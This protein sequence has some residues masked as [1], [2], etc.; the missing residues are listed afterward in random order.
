METLLKIEQILECEGKLQIGKDDD[1]LSMYLQYYYS[2]R[3]KRSTPI[4]TRVDVNPKGLFPTKCVV[5]DF[6]G[7]LS[8]QKDRT[9]WELIWEQLGY[10][11]DDCARLH[12]K[13]SNNV[14]T[15]E[16]WCNETCALF[17]KKGISRNTLKEVADSIILMA[18]V[19]SMLETL[20]NANIEIHILSGSIYEI[21]QEV[22]GDLAK[23]FTHIQANSFKFTAN[24]LSYIESTKYD[25]EGKAKYIKRLMKQKK[26]PVN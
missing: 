23:Y 3:K 15:H 5:F 10:S 22:I 12:R 14:I 1:L 19:K 16:E 4:G 25:F 26:L 7:T 21:I 17:N 9:T 8:I 18:G 24:T 11:I 20:S 2:N 6:D 13:F